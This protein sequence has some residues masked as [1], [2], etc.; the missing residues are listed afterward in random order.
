MESPLKGKCNGFQGCADTNDTAF[1]VDAKSY[2]LPITTSL[3]KFPSAEFGR[4][5]IPSASLNPSWSGFIANNPHLSPA[6]IHELKEGWPT[7]LPAWFMYPETRET[8]M[9]SIA[10]PR[11][12]S[13]GS[14][15]PRSASLKILDQIDGTD[16]IKNQ[17]R[18][19]NQMKPVNQVDE[20][21]IENDLLPSIPFNLNRDFKFP[22]RQSIDE[23][24]ILESNPQVMR[25]NMD[26][27][28]PGPSINY[29]QK[30]FS[31]TDDADWVTEANSQAPSRW[32]PGLRTHITSDSLADNSDR[33]S[34]LSIYAEQFPV[35]LPPPINTYQHPSPLSDHHSNPFSSSPPNLEAPKDPELVL[36]KNRVQAR[37]MELEKQGEFTTYRFPR[38]VHERKKP[39]PPPKSEARR[40]YARELSNASFLPENDVGRNWPL[41]DDLPYSPETELSTENKAQLSLDEADNMMAHDDPRTSMDIADLPLVIERRVHIPRLSSAWLS[42]VEEATDEMKSSSGFESIYSITVPRT[43][44]IGSDDFS[45]HELNGRDSSYLPNTALRTTQVQ[46]RS[47]SVTNYSNVESFRASLSSLNVNAPSAYMAG[48][49]RDRERHHTV[50]HIRNLFEDSDEDDSDAFDPS[51]LRFS[52]RPPRNTS[53]RQRM[54]FQR[55]SSEGCLYPPAPPPSIAP[56]H[57][58]S[59]EEGHPEVAVPSPASTKWPSPRMS[60][61]KELA[62]G[63]GTQ[64]ARG[65]KAFANVK[66][67]KTLNEQIRLR[68]E[69]QERAPTGRGFVMTPRRD[70]TELFGTPHLEATP[71]ARPMDYVTHR[72]YLSTTILILSLCVPPTAIIVGHGYAD[73]LMMHISNG[74][75][76]RLSRRVEIV[77]LYL[78]YIQVVAALCGLLFWIGF[79]VAGH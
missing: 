25:D 38:E 37:V 22:A 67:Q 54:R 30:G 9:A 26:I 39:T 77:G 5:P 64:V 8:S 32:D 24:K 7:K 73:G 48:P 55:Q 28:R 11:Q 17:T 57:Q 44:K 29:H 53:P 71:H 65:Y 23:E 79:R 59:I 51:P 4:Q 6:Q 36:P 21:A 45:G 74:N 70:F 19:P 33:S 47:P 49:D 10:R 14:R 50:V 27:H 35:T 60:K 20:K 58:F 15:R 41:D 2:G 68:L 16:K 40:L 3:P 66:D 56:S 34:S 1:Q 12:E 52:G 63:Y 13:D 31:G 75:H 43:S 69:L 46:A 76:N 61:W 18:K 62:T 42:T 72:L 78:G